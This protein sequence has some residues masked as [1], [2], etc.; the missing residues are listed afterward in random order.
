[1]ARRSGKTEKLL[2]AAH[3]KAEMRGESSSFS[4]RWEAEAREKLPDELVVLTAGRELLPSDD[5]TSSRDASPYDTLAKPDAVA[6]DASRE[7]LN[8]LNEA[9]ALALGLDLADS[10]Q[11]QNSLEKA[12]LHQMGTTHAAHLKMAAQ[13]N[14]LLDSMAKLEPYG[15]KNLPTEACRLAGA[16]TRLAGAYQGGMTTLQRVRSGGRQTVIVQHTYV[17]DGGQAVV[18]GQAKGGGQPRRRQRR[19]GTP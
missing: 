9:D 15:W 18:A 14:R 13:M 12:L 10:A 3:C 4:D 2:H 7:R 19:G 17:G 6:A 11:A 16:M 1:M 8:L 5:F